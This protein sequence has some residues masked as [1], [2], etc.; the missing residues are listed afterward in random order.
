MTINSSGKV[1]IGTKT[2]G[3]HRLAVEG[4]IGAREVN[5]N[6]NSWPDYVFKDKYDLIS[7]DDLK[8]FINSHQHLPEIPSEQDVLA[9]GID[10]GEMN[11]LLL[12][13]IE[14]L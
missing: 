3:N 12:K 5:V 8:E 6:L 4:S 13:K 10:V 9:A 1:G 2:T 7:L 11:A 14:E